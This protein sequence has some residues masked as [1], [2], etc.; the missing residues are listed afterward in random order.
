MHSN[1]EKRLSSTADDRHSTLELQGFCVH[2]GYVNQ[3]YIL[4][5]FTPDKFLASDSEVLN[6]AAAAQKKGL[7][8]EETAASL[9]LLLLLLP[10]EIKLNPV[11]VCVSSKHQIYMNCCW[12]M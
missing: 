6:G 2:T 9:R 7:V 1:G 4:T 3:D 12:E 8:P 11:V 5:Y 10:D